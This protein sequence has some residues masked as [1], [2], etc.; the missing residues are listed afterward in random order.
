M[1]THLRDFVLT[2]DNGW[3]RSLEDHGHH[4]PLKPIPVTEEAAL[5]RA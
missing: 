1:P 3:F 5:V 2:F 4:T